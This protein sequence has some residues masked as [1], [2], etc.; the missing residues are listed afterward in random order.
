V[1]KQEW[2]ASPLFGI[3]VGIESI[4]Q[5]GELFVGDLLFSVQSQI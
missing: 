3:Y 4:G 2:G 1:Q 5:T